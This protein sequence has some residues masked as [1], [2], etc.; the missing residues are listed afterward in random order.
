M[1]SSYRYYALSASLLVQV[2]LGAIYAW[3]VFVGPLRSAAGITQ[4]VAQLP[5]TFFY[6][7]FPFTMLF[8]GRLLHRFGPRVCAMTGGVVFG[9]GWLLASLGNFSFLWTVAGIGVL[10]GIGVGIVY[11]VPIAVLVRWFPASRGAVTGLAVA[12]FG[13][14]ALLISQ[15]AGALIGSGMSP[16]EVFRLLGIVFLIISVPAGWLMIFPSGGAGTVETPLAA[17][18]VLR[19]PE[20]VVLYLCMITGLA[21]GFAVNANLRDLSN[22]GAS[23]AGLIAVGVF[24]VAN[25][26]G[27]PL[28]GFIFDRMRPHTVITINLAGQA[29]LLFSA[30]LWLRGD[31]GYLAFAMLAGLH[32]GGVLVLYAA[33]V[34]R[35]WGAGQVGQVYGWMFSANM[36]AAPAA[37]LSGAWF[38]AGGGF[39]VPLAMI[40][41]CMACAAFVLWRTA[42]IR[43][44]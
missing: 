21:A 31:A 11:V 4:T 17:R 8:A 41:L 15:A 36:L 5:F 14:G 6:F 26:A 27:R 43:A 32:Y 44:V 13:G 3:S 29:L 33:M 25:A 37:T 1:S 12:G 38:D 2:C 7:C 19:R 10:A 16:F 34:V 28:W 23:G 20:F 40:A 24:A 18:M 22:H 35:I 39:L 30:G 42:S 9:A